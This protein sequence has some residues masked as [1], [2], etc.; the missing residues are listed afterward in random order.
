MGVLQSGS[1]G[2]PLG[3]TELPRRRGERCAIPAKRRRYPHAMHHSHFLPAML[4][5]SLAASQHTAA[6]RPRRRIFAGASWLKST[7]MRRALGPLITP[8][9]WL[10]S[11]CKAPNPDEIRA[12][13]TRSP[14]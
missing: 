3:Q 5:L 6:D 9:G 14:G 11:P 12:T 13:R 2:C 4:R 10:I 7:D 8:A 1:L